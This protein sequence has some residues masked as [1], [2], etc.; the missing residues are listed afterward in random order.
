M[1]KYRNRKTVVDGIEFASK[2]EAERYKF[3][4]ILEKTGQIKD[5][6]TQVKFELQPSF[7]YHDKQIRAIYYVA[8]FVYFRDGKKVVEDTKGFI[9]EVYK[10][11]SKMFLF[12]NGFEITEI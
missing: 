6:K 3:L 10:L 1:Q 4:R 2:K 12:K 9:T 8:D 11:K 7:R 5:L